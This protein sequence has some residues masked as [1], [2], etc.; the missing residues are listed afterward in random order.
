MRSGVITPV[1]AERRVTPSEIDVIGCLRWLL[2][3]RMSSDNGPSSPYSV[4]SACQ[5]RLHL[6]TTVPSS[7]RYLA[8]WI[9]VPSSPILFGHLRNFGFV[10]I[11]PPS[12]YVNVW[13]LVNYLIFLFGH[14]RGR[15]VTARFCTSVLFLCTVL[16][17]CKY[18]KFSYA[19]DV[20]K[21][22]YLS[23]LLLLIK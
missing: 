7:H 8:L 11:E 23:I 4:H 10:V 5:L 16:E 21:F 19:Q 13:F 3:Y 6:V 9:S 2:S 1:R 12:W 18:I 14:I 17:I 22:D 20:F 15:T